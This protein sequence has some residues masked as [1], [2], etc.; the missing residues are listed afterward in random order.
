MLASRQ[1][2]PRTC[3]RRR[4]GADKR[5]AGGYGCG[6][7]ARGPPMMTDAENRSPIAAAAQALA[8][9]AFALLM[10][11]P[12]ITTL[13]PLD[14]DESRFMQASVQMLETGDYVAIRFQDA[15]RNKKPAGTYW[16]QAASV[17]AVS[18]VEARAVW[19]HR[20]PSMV[21]AVLGVLLVYGAGARLF[22][23]EVG[24][25]AAL[26]CAAAP[27]LA[28]EATIAKS[29]ALL[30]ASIVA[31]QWALASLA[32]TSRTGSSSGRWAAYAFWAAMAV[33]ALIKGPIA[34]MV[35]VLTLV[36]ISLTDLGASVWRRLR[37]VSGAIVFALVVAPWTV[38]IT[39]QTDGRFI[40]EAVGVDMLG[41]VTQAQE[42]HGAPFGLHL[43]LLPIL[44][45]PVVPFLASGVWRGVRDL[46]VD[47]V[48]FSFFWLAPGWLLFEIATTKLPHYVLPLYPAL[49][50]LAARVIT[51]GETRLGLLRAG[52]ALHLVLGAAFAA[53]LIAI[54]AV[55]SSGA[56]GWTSPPPLAA[57]GAAGL[58]GLT[59]ATTVLVW[60]GALKAGA[61]ASALAGAVLAWAVMEASLPAARD[62]D[63]SRRIS[64]SL[65]AA[66]LH[67]R[68]DGAD[69]AVLTG[70]Y[71][72]SA[73]FL[74][75]TDTI[76]AAPRQ[77]AASFAARGGSAVVEGRERDAFC[78]TL[79]ETD[80][81]A[82]PV[83]EIEGYN[84]SKGRKVRLTIFARDAAGDAGTTG[85]CAP[86][87]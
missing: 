35:G 2:R 41:K 34:P 46:D 27:S 78:A 6:D 3:A 70:Y 87:D 77:A 28:G 69:V 31:M 80:A 71:E 68:L 10:T 47:A 79:E 82:R 63:V 24:F 17:A 65:D 60:R 45:W 81:L 43:A 52:A 19:A 75:G 16:A 58:L 29:D 37:P 20:L 51:R 39:L 21:A 9:A 72:P 44:F 49:A 64:A 57:A 26:L 67:P 62:L 53:G 14:R 33:G 85:G 84:Y 38:A 66:G 5:E 13:P 55:F 48:R 54:P 76:L 56:Y 23:R 74:L 32:R 22:T 61:V 73:V 4:P 25:F 15:E 59:L 86:A 40:T 1:Q 11:A 50:I 83:D 30:F 18:S 8:L 12:G 36:G 7:D 42:N